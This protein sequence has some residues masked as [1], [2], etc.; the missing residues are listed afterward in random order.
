[1]N[2]IVLSI[3]IPAYN[4]MEF[5]SDCLHSIFDQ[6]NSSIEVILIDDGSIDGTTDFVEREFNTLVECRRLIL[7]RQANLGPGAARN[8]GLEIARG[9]Y[10]TFLDSDDLLLDGYFR[11]IYP[12]LEIGLFDIIEHGFI[13]FRTK[14][15]F[16]LVKYKPLY[17]FSGLYSLREIRNSVFSKTVWYPSIRIF[18]NNIWK[19]LR[20]P[21]GVCYEDPM[22]IHK[23]FLGDYN[24]YYI[25]EPFLG[26]R[27]NPNSITSRH[28]GSHMLDLVGLYRT[29]SND[30]VPMQIFKVR[31]AR[32][33]LYFYHELD[34]HKDIM[35]DVLFD[36]RSMP[37]HMELLR[38][39][40][41][42]DLFFL[43]FTD[44]YIIVNRLRL[45]G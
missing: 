29:L 28:S 15:D 42:V 11:K 41:V 20:F 23:I 31:L 3:I 12:L 22:T 25:K 36:M 24:I 45:Q 35:E 19:K 26:Y 8:R 1:M 17:S 33:I 32:S 18:K 4:S 5:I 6:A 10:I 27:N 37:W 44:I 9:R 21:E 30:S 34:A 39:L 7:I 40:T 13:R 16:S 14:E 38:S 43:I 2:D